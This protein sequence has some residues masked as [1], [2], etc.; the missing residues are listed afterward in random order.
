M[1]RLRSFLPLAAVICLE[2]AAIVALRAAGGVARWR[3]DFAHFWTWLDVTPTPDVVAG[4]ARTAALVLVSYLA[5]TTTAYLVATATRSATLIR[6]ASPW[7]LPG[8]RRVVEGAVAVTLVAGAL[9]P[10]V[11][12][13]QA[14]PTAGWARPGA[15]ATAQVLTPP[16]QAV[17]PDATQAGTWTVEEGHNLWSI[18]EAVTTKVTGIAPEQLRSADVAPYWQSLVRAVTPQLVSG[19]PSLIY[20]GEILTLPP[21][22][23]ATVAPAPAPAAAPAPTPAADP[24]VT[25]PADTAPPVTTPATV[26]PA[27][28]APALTAAPAT[29]PAWPPAQPAAPATAPAAPVD[30]AGTPAA[31][32]TSHGS[33]LPVLPGLFG[34]GL[35]SAGVVLALRRRRAARD[36]RRVEGEVAAPPDPKLEPVEFEALVGADIGG[37]SFV[38]TALRALGAGLT[39]DGP[40]PEAVMLG[41]HDITVHMDEAG[42]APEPFAG[43]GHVWTLSRDTD[44]ATLARIAGARPMPLPALVSLGR[45]VEADEVLLDLEGPGLVSIDGAG[46]TELVV[47]AML[48]LCTST[49]EEVAS[50][51]AV[52]FDPAPVAH[53]VRCVATLAEVLDDLDQ[54]AS[55][56]AALVDDS[57]CGTTFG[58]RVSGANNDPWIPTVVVCASAPTD[59]DA[60]RLVA[61]CTDRDRAGV[62]ALVA[63]H[64][65]DSPWALTIDH[66]RLGLDD[67]D[68]TIEVP[69]AVTETQ[70]TAIVELLANA[71][72]DPVPAPVS[73][74]S[75][76]VANDYIN[77]SD[78][79]SLLVRVMGA[80]RVEGCG[81]IQRTKGREILVYLATHRDEQIDRD[82]LVERIWPASPDPDAAA[83][84]L[85][86]TISSLRSDVGAAPDGSAHIPALRGSERLYRLGDSVGTDVEMLRTALDQAKANA[87]EA[88]REALAAALG[89]VTGPAFDH[90]SHGYEWAASE[91]LVRDVELVVT[92]AAHRLS[93]LYLE[94]GE[95]ERAEWAANQGLV[96]ARGHEQ[97]FRDVMQARSAAGNYGGVD[98]AWEDLLGTLDGDDPSAPTVAVY[99]RA[100][101][102]SGAK[103][104]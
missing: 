46:S 72:A 25:A 28:T 57:G 40:V 71:E 70:S 86:T 51:V 69:T 7:T 32:T 62:A 33:S 12:S 31:V 81:D 78:M 10:R 56:T 91:G 4:L 103:V 99:R 18:A 55:T 29:A 36:A 41:S 92:D 54:E 52:G 44:L 66:G 80:P 101:E 39:H 95:C 68:L 45:T 9:M 21:D 77:D 24:V 104:A 8:I 15:V 63:G 5:L 59:G 74:E 75:I 89:L 14:L 102:R 22:L 6:F 37:A 61:I 20:P 60:R 90:V 34:A 16:G 93:A 100:R 30:A 58:A 73:S 17:A 48:Q 97:L 11:A 64:V 67:L 53:H 87:S 23:A 35:L 49:W 65:P 85:A 76:D 26:A 1:K 2:A 79:P 47:A 96:L 94:A 98:R 3:V 43:G 27:D 19:D 88:N 38:E 13:A 82:R 50:V 84:N 42:P 83:R